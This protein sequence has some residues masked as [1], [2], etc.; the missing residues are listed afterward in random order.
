MA[1]KN[2]EPNCLVEALLTKEADTFFVAKVGKVYG[3]GQKTEKD[4]PALEHM[5]GFYARLM[6]GQGG[7]FIPVPEDLVASLRPDIQKGLANRTLRVEVSH[8]I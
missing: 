5:M 3:P 2:V 6:F 7:Y 1:T 4:L 8:V